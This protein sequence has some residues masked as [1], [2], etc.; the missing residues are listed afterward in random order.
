MV[1]HCGA[2]LR[3][4]VLKC[5]VQPGFHEDDLMQ[6]VVASCSWAEAPWEVRRQAVKGLPEI[7][8]ALECEMERGLRWLAAARRKAARLLAIPPDDAIAAAPDMPDA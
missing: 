5:E 4:F 2:S 3:F 8:D 7:L 1:D 6:H